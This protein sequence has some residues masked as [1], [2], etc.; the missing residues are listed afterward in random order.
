[1]KTIAIKKFISSIT[2]FLFV[3]V[4]MPQQQGEQPPPP[5]KPPTIEE[6]IKKTNEVLQQEV[7][8]NASQKT[9]VEKAY[10]KFFEAA[11]K[12]RKDKPGLP[13]SPPDAK[14]KEEMDKLMKER[15]KSVKMVLTSDQYNKYKEAVKKLRPPEPGGNN[16]PPPPKH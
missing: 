15:D 14:T 5:P 9:A 1:M 4:A 7:Q 12:L 2:L 8:L 13:P 11:D 3:I 6:R 16:L 10:S